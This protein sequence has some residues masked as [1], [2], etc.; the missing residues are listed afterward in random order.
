M[1]PLTADAVVATIGDGR[2]FTNGR[3]LSAWLGLTPTQHSSGGKQRLGEISR[4]G[5]SYLRTL[6]IQGARSSLQRANAVALEKASAEQIWIRGL[7]QRLP[8]GKVLVAIA[9]KHA[10]QLWAMLACDEDYDAEPW[11]RHPMVQRPAK[12]KTRAIAA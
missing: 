1:G 4:R 2:E 6:L 12:H 3:Q 10:L 8:F 7:A 5:D 9:N 11:L